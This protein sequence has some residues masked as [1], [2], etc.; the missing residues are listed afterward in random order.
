MP[1][2]FRGIPV[3]NILEGWERCLLRGDGYAS[4]FFMNRPKK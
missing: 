2:F 4:F 3:R 1:R